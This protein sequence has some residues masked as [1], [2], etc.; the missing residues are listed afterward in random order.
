M[1]ASIE[2]RRTSAQPQKSTFYLVA[3]GACGGSHLTEIGEQRR[4]AVESSGVER[5]SIEYMRCADTR[6][7][8]FRATFPPSI[9]HQFHRSTSHDTRQARQ[10][11]FVDYS[12]RWHRACG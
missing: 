10:Q 4:R 8:P 7:T 9:N 2:I 3:V 1:V 5:V 6:I 11:G 12:S